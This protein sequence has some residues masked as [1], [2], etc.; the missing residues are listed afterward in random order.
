MDKV[1]V[2]NN[3]KKFGSVSACWYLEEIEWEFILYASLF[4]PSLF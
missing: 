1:L 4:C 2:W 3:K